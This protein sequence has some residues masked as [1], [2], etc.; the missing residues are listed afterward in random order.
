MDKNFLTFICPYC[1][2]KFTITG[3]KMNRILV[4][5]KNLGELIFFYL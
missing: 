1:E 2:N 4:H 3:N 5:K